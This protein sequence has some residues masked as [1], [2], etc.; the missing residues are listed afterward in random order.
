MTAAWNVNSP[1]GCIVLLD[2][3]QRTSMSPPAP[4]FARTARKTIP[5]GPDV[6]SAISA[7][8]GAAGSAELKVQSPSSA[9][10]RFVELAVVAV[11]AARKVASGVDVDVG[12]AWYGSVETGEAWRPEVEREAKGLCACGYAAGLV[13]LAVERADSGVEVLGSVKSRDLKRS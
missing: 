2:T 13:V 1:T 12:D 5:T 8:V 3:T 10:L 7:S 11:E 6:A 4:A 9:L